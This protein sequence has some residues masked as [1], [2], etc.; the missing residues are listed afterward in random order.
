MDSLLQ[1]LCWRYTKAR[2]IACT[3]ALRQRLQIIFHTRF[4]LIPE[5]SPDRSFR[6]PPQV[7]LR[8]TCDAAYVQHHGYES[9]ADNDCVTDPNHC[10][11]TQAALRPM[12]CIAPAS[13]SPNEHVPAHDRSLTGHPLAQYQTAANVGC[14]VQKTDVQHIRM[15]Q[16]VFWTPKMTV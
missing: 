6:W 16:I 8:K 10:T 5:V 14:N 7:V 11:G 9:R 13:Q 12:S 2:A 1:Q 3:V 4:Q 15:H